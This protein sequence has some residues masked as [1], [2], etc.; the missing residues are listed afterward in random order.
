MR[1]TLWPCL[2]GL[3]LLVG[4]AT[5]RAAELE[6]RLSTFVNRS[7][8]D[9][10]RELGVPTRTVQA[11]G[12]TFLAYTRTRRVIYGGGWGGPWWGGWGPGWATPAEAVDLTCEA[13]FEIH[14]GTVTNVRVH[15]DGC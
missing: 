10:V 8:A 15:G 14:G 5:Q 4:C 7:E 11:D 12:A 6:T 13:T 3:L 9:V 1:S 2:A